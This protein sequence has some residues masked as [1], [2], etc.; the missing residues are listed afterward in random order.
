MTQVETALNQATNELQELLEG[1]EYKSLQDVSQ[2]CDKHWHWIS[3]L[4]ASCFCLQLACKLEDAR[5]LLAAPS[6]ARQDLDM[7]LHAEECGSIAEVNA[8]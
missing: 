4:Y 2:H 6:Q 5:K 3:H 7:L 1:T 8:T